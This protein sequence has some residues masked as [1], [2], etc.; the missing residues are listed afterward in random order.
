MCVWGGGGGAREV[1]KG[2]GGNLSEHCF[3]C[4]G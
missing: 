3:Q 2:S 4:E 1:E